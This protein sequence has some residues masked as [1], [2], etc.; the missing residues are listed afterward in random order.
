[1]GLIEWWH[2]VRINLPQHGGGLALSLK[3][4]M[5]RATGNR[6]GRLPASAEM[7]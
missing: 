6:C 7:E 4:K 2:L 3:A 1:M 5:I